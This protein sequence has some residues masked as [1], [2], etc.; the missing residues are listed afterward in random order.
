MEE[1]VVIRHEEKQAILKIMTEITD[2]YKLSEG[3]RFIKELAMFFD[4]ANELSEACCMPLSDAQN[5][6]KNIKY[7][8]TSKRI[9]I[10]E[11]FN[12]LLIDKRI[13]TH[14]TFQAYCID[15]ISIIGGFARYYDFFIKAFNPI[16]SPVYQAINV[17]HNGSTII[18][19]N[20]Y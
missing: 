9:F 19:I 7:N 2:H 10:V 11:L 3:D 16:D 4:M 5:I 17:G 18:Q 13:K 12:W 6:L 15:A 20:K 1:I 8:H 14:E